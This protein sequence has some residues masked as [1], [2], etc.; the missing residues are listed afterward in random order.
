MNNSFRF[1]ITLSGP[2]RYLTNYSETKK[3]ILRSEISIC[4]LYWKN[5]HSWTT[6][7]NQIK[8]RHTYKSTEDNLTGGSV[9]ASGEEELVSDEAFLDICLY[10]QE[11]S[12]NVTTAELGDTELGL[13][14][15][16]NVTGTDAVGSGDEAGRTDSGHSFGWKIV[17]RDLN[18]GRNG[19][20]ILCRF[21]LLSG[22][23]NCIRKR[24]PKSSQKSHVRSYEFN[25]MKHW[26]TCTCR[27][28]SKIVT[29]SLSLVLTLFRT[30]DL[31]TYIS[32]VSILSIQHFCAL[33]NHLYNNFAVSEHLKTFG[34][35]SETLKLCV[36]FCDTLTV[37]DWVDD[38]LQVVYGAL[39]A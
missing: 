35:L 6:F 24:S 8:L 28:N 33:E 11:M 15:L 39:Q 7:P 17:Y 26:S 1:D 18:L 29:D 32:A 23:P 2:K 4:N 13:L 10:G 25:K 34:S 30:L 37:V 22:S 21:I 16:D 12:T 38:L 27:G 36:S 20:G 19:R 9:N 14:F 3:K 5:W 31:S